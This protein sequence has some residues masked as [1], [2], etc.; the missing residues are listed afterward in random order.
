MKDISAADNENIDRALE[1][2]TKAQG[3]KSLWSDMKNNAAVACARRIPTLMGNGSKVKGA[4]VNVAEGLATHDN[5]EVHVAT[6]SAGA[7]LLGHWIDVLA[8]RKIELKTVSL[9][10]PACS[11]KFS[12]DY[13]NKAVDKKVFKKTS[14][15]IDMLSD[16]RERAD[17]FGS[18]NKSL[19][20]LVSR[21]LEDMHKEPMLG[22]QATWTRDNNNNVYRDRNRIEPTDEEVARFDAIDRLLEFWKPGL[23]KTIHD[24][25]RRTVNYSVKHDVLELSH[26]SFDNDIEVVEA[27]IKRMLRKRKLKYP[28]ENLGGF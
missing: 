24:K 3:G 25:E 9:S 28:I 5:V 16:E 27:A 14:V 26:R 6:H 18:Y 1:V 15:F 20:Y 22:M 21:A 8:R 23:K 11:V 12:N 10:A 13:F 19:L 17:K 2:A 4:M 7:I